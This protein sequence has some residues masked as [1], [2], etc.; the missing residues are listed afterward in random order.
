MTD[1]MPVETIEGLD[2][3]AVL[4][5]RR[6]I[7]IICVAASMVIGFMIGAFITPQFTAT[8]TAVPAVDD[9]A[10]GSAAGALSGLSFL[11]G[12]STTSRKDTAVALL[13]ARTTLQNFIVQNNLLPVLFQN[14]WDAETGKWK[15]GAK[16]PTLE[17]GYLTLKA[18]VKIEQDTVAGL[19]KLNVTW[20]NSD[21]A[22]RWCN[23]LMKVTNDTMQSNAVQRSDRMI[24]YLNPELDRIQN[25]EVR[26]NVASLIQE[27]IKAKVLAKSNN[28][29]ALE[30]IDPALPT[31]AKSSLGKGVLTVIGIFFGLVV[32]IPLTFF[33]EAMAVRRARR[34]TR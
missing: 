28:N 3:F 33:L 31:T 11:T 21:I 34:T 19:I 9:T 1:L 27:Q 14:R 13:D 26:T 2:Y 20:R 16:P 24:S 4:F 7:V 17:D 32:S 23:G 6:L 8:A 10:Q 25:Q 29:Y 15:D 18:H 22:A 5:K 12:H 30:V